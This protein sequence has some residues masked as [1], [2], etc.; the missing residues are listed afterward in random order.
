MRMQ[1]GDYTVGDTNVNISC[2]VDEV[3]TGK[4][5]DFEFVKPSGETIVRDATSIS[6][7]TATYTWASGDL[8]EA[9]DWYAFLKDAGS[10]FYYTK[11]SG[12]H[13]YVRPKPADMAVDL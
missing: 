13:F 5:V 10:V 12:H 2:T 7:Y 11:E 6:G 3:L 8:D 9:G 1:K 4:N